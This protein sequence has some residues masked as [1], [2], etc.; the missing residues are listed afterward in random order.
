MET[1]NVVVCKECCREITEEEFKEYGGLC[2]K[3]YGLKQEDIESTNNYEM[4]KHNKGE[5]IQLLENIKN[6]WRRINIMKKEIIIFIVT[7][8]L[9][10]LSIVLVVKGLEFIKEGFDVKE[11]YYYSSN[12]S[13]LNKHAYVG[14]DAYNYIIN[15]NYFTGY[16][17]LGC[18]SI[19]CATISGA[20]AILINI[21]RYR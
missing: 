4:K 19:I 9:A 10:I 11:N 16:M 3:C 15:A 5:I 6:K 7:I 2:K 12:Y 13:L 21:K 17:V 1:K 20:I 8:I 14:G 18:S